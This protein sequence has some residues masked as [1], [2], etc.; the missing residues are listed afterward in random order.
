MLVEKRR[1][2]QFALGPLVIV[3]L[4]LIFRGAGSTGTPLRPETKR[5]GMTELEAP[6][7][8]GQPWRLSDHRGS[9]ILVNFWATWCPPCRMET[10]GLVS[11]YNQYRGK[12]LEVV[13]ISMDDGGPDAVRQFVERYKITYPVALP[14][15]DSP[16]ASAISSLPTT[17][18]IDRQGRVARTYYGAEDEATFRRDVD[19]LLT[20]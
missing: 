9:V 14:K 5:Q 10:P 8:D 16:L 19:R 6:K 2:A 15:P 11:L 3:A 1:I 4:F 13:G 17:L 20:E 12:G 18:L 7:L